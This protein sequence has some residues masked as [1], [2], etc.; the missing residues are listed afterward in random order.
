MSA[1]AGSD[2]TEAMLRGMKVS[3]AGIAVMSAVVFLL[4]VLKIGRK[5]KSI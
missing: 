3:F 4:A 2:K 5:R 1:V